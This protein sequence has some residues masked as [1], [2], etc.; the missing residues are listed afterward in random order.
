MGLSGFSGGILYFMNKKNCIY[1]TLRKIHPV[2]RLKKT[3]EVF[4]LE[5]PSFFISGKPIWILKRG[6]PIS[7]K[8]ELDF[9]QYV[10]KGYSSDEIDAKINSI[11]TN[12]IFRRNFI[13]KTT[14]ITLIL[15]NII[16]IMSTY[17]I[18]GVK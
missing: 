7:I 10:E 8:M 6:N 4:K 3:N 9:E 1:I 18:M 11:Y 14:I 17:I 12:S 13:N 5:K 2:I 15:S 16:S